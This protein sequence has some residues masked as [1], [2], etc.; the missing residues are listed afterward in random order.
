MFTVGYLDPSRTSTMELFSLRL[1]HIRLNHIQFD[2][3]AFQVPFF[4]QLVKKR[5]TENLGRKSLLLTKEQFFFFLKFKIARWSGVIS[6]EGFL[7]Q[8]L[9][10]VLKLL[11]CFLFSLF[12]ILWSKHLQKVKDKKRCCFRR[13]ICRTP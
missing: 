13:A 8:H 11:H 2:R 10:K 5:T 4:T 3:I 12:Q 7:N 9:L 6:K 1:K